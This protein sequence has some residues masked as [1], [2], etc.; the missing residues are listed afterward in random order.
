MVRKTTHATEAMKGDLRLA[1]FK[2]EYNH[3]DNRVLLNKD[4]IIILIIKENNN[5]TNKNEKM[6]IDKTEKVLMS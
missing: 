3:N 1:D 6:L 5:N 2:N 4:L